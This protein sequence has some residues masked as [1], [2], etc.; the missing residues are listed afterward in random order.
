MPPESGGMG[1]D[2]GGGTGSWEIRSLSLHSPQ[3]VRRW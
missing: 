3:Q 2:R 1:V